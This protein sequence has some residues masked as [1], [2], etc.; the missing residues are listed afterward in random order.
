MSQI[1]IYSHLTDEELLRHISNFKHHSPIIEELAQ[2]LEKEIVEIVED[3]NHTVKCP[4]CKAVLEADYD[5]GENKFT[6][7]IE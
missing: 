4:V 7:I 3:A 2:R 6:L 1:T 5:P